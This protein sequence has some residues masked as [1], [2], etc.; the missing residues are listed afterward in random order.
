LLTTNTTF[1]SDPKT[2]AEARPDN[3]ARIKLTS[4][5]LGDVHPLFVWSLGM[6]VIVEIKAGERSK[7]P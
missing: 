4:A 5:K 1:N 3:K 7:L 6:M 2:D